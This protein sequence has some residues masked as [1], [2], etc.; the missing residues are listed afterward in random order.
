MLN[1]L[2]LS[3]DPCERGLGG[4]IEM[5]FIPRV[6]IASMGI[7]SDLSF[8]GPLTIKPGWRW[9]KLEMQDKTNFYNEDFRDTPHGELYDIS[10]GG[11]YPKDD[12]NTMQL[13]AKMAR[14]Y[15]LVRARD[16]EG[17]WR[18]VGNMSETLKLTKRSFSST[19]PDNRVGYVIEFGAAF[20]R[21]GLVDNRV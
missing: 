17:R 2:L 3:G 21:P 7:P 15:Y 13:L 1:D 10:V 18:I 11:F 8:T 12:L 16:Y 20:K 6:A 9:Y 14:Y 5:Q 19:T 4:I